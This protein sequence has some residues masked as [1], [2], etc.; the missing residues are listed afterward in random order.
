MHLL[1]V[2]SP[3]DHLSAHGLL[4]RAGECSTARR[5]T[6]EGQVRPAEYGA[7]L[8]A[9]RWATT[10]SASASAFPA[11]AAVASGNTVPLEAM[12]TYTVDYTGIPGHVY[13]LLLESGRFYVGWSSAVEN[14]IAQHF[15]GAGSKWTM[16][17]KPLQVL[18]CVAGDTRL[19]D[20]VTISLMCQHGWERVRGGRW[21]QLALEG[22]P[23]AVTRAMPPPRTSARALQRACRDRRRAKQ[24]LAGQ[25]AERGA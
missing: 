6:S 7:N 21:C 1:Q 22:P 16:Q 18:A 14:R 25:C 10:A 24:R 11:E 17:H 8:A 3:G 13:T 9:R 5:P 15:S 4:H 12:A 23:D 2:C 19:E 20:V